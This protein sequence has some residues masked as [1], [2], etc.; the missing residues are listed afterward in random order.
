MIV[1][2][3]LER[4]LPT[5]RKPAR[6]TG[7]EWN[8]VAK[9]WTTCRVRWALAFPDIYDIGMS[10]FGLAILYDVL[11]R[12][13]GVLAER[14]FAPWTDMEQ[15]L[16]AAGLPLFS[17]ESRRPLGEFDVLGFTLPY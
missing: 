11:N 17:L 9:D 1:H 4:I 13:P 14:V 8:S 6:Y 7:G 10:N 2:D 3:T 15:A 12:E 5:V 16:R